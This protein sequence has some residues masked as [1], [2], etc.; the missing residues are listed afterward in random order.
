MTYHFSKILEHT[1]ENS[2]DK[3]KESLKN[4]GFGV[5][6]EI[7]IKKTFKEK[8]D[9]N[10]N[11]YLILGACNPNYALKAISSENKI[12]TMLPCNVVVQELPDGKIEVSAVDPVASM[13]AIQNHK[14]GEIASEVQL[15]LK[16]VI[17]NLK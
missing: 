11:N 7:D 2:V 14:L 1:F 13:M 9:V 8:L 5:V 17:E 6:S 16:K 4:E 12:G 15:K 10:F 3:V